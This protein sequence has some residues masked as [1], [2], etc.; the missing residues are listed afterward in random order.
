MRLKALLE[1]FTKSRPA[2]GRTLYQ[3]TSDV[4]GNDVTHVVVFD[5]A[6]DANHYMVSMLSDAGGSMGSELPLSGR[7]LSTYVA[8][9]QDMVE[10]GEMVK[11]FLRNNNEHAI[12]H[13][14][15]YLSRNIGMPDKRIR[16]KTGPKHTS[17]SFR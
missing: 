17:F 13:I 2:E 8:I 4:D 9:I 12:P 7:V 3:F 16:V 1:S 10:S 5:A 14:V 15:R 6:S 11:M